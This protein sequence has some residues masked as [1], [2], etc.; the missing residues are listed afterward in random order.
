M[1]RK[2]AEQ[3]GKGILDSKEAAFYEFEADTLQKAID[4][5]RP[6]GNGSES[7]SNTKSSSRHQNSEESKRRL[8]FEA[9]LDD[10]ENRLR[11]KI[12]VVGGFA[13]AEVSARKLVSMFRY[14][15]Q[16]DSKQIDFKEFFNAMSKLNFI[17][18][19]REIEALFHRYDDV[20]PSTSPTRFSVPDTSFLIFS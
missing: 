16:N 2:A 5:D 18:L 11:Q 6:Y 15:D 8:A 20:R 10:L 19:H 12:E 13:D 14:F 7:K 1:S 9:R 3:L 4:E 17:G